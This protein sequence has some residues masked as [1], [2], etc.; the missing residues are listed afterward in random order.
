MTQLM[1]MVAK[2]RKTL[3]PPK[4]LSGSQWADQKAYLSPEDSAEAGKYRCDR[5]EFQRGI[6]DAVTDKTIIGVVVMKS[7]QVG[8]TQI[9]KNIIGYYIDQDP[10][11]MMMVQPTAGMAK[12]FSKDRLAPMLRDTPAL[13]GKV[14]SARERDSGNTVLHKQFAG[15]HLTL[16]AAASASELASRPIR[17]ALL[18]EV[19]RYKANVSGEGDPC[20]LVIA[21]LKTFWNSKWMMGSTPTRSNESRIFD[22]FKTSDQ[23]YFYVKCPHCDEAQTFKFEFMRWEEGNPSTAFYACEH[24]GCVI[25]DADKNLMVRNGEWIATAKFNGIAGFHISELYSPFSSW[26]KIAADYEI[27]KET[28]EQLQTFYNTVLGLPYEAASDGVD[29]ADFAALVDDYE[30]NTVPDGVGVLTGF[31]DIQKDRIEYS[32]WGFGRNLEP[33]LINHDVMLGSIN[34]PNF[35]ASVAAEIRGLSYENQHGDTLVLKQVGVD[36]GYESKSAYDLVRLIGSKACATKGVGGFGRDMVARPSYKD[37]TVGGKV[38]KRGMKLFALGVDV[39]KIWTYDRF[40]LGANQVGRAHFPVGMS[41]DYFEQLAA[42][43]L[44]IQN[45]RGYKVRKWITVNLR[46]EALDCFVG[47]LSMALVVG[48]DKYTSRTW[49]SLLNV[50]AASEFTTNKNDVIVEKPVERKIS[51]WSR[52]GQKNGGNM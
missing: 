3:L 45:V 6:Q 9:L 12:S 51:A 19:D 25:D 27:K 1:E 49:D 47:C 36:S 38:I 32:V 29:A 41:D 4:N 17:I 46:N 44:Q 30:K 34:D 16:A 43:R 40:S 7:A 39:A 21:R 52:L 24:N 26:A 33:Y 23:R 35:R 22:A 15:G 31:I 10:S 2:C 11:P 20:A 28:P 14:R 8:Y 42:E 48:V 50:R 37:Y 13:R 5:V 18:D